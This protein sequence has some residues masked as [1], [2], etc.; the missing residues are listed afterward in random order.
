MPKY[1]I[2]VSW[3][4]DPKELWRRAAG[5]TQEEAEAELHAV[6]MNLNNYR[7]LARIERVDDA[8]EGGKGA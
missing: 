4:T 2:I 5:D 3:S 7:F 8:D 1:F 6:Q